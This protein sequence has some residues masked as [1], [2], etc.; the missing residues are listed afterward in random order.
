MEITMNMKKKILLRSLTGA[1]IGLTI[2]TFI[3]IVFS[4]LLGNGEYF[5]VPYELA[6]ACGSE[7][8]AV[9]LQTVF[10]MLYGA[11]WAGGSVIWEI[12]NWSLL[13]MTLTHLVLLSAV[14][15]PIAWFLQWIPHQVRGACLFFGIFFVIYAGVWISRY[16][17][18]RKQVE[19]I[20]RGLKELE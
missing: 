3:T 5:P 7:I 10:S 19:E 14:T 15:F 16:L 13:R 18:I 4:A 9:I 6:A 20:N 8:N 17:A 2:S 1:P 12:E 11:V